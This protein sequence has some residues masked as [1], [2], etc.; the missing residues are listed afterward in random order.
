MLT[1]TVDLTINETIIHYVRCTPQ[2]RGS[3][4]SKSTRS[5]GFRLISAERASEVWVVSPSA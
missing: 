2:R 4:F 3:P 5:F 1:C